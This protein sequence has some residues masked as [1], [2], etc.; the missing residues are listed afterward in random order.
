MEMRLDTTLVSSVRST[1]RE[2]LQPTVPV[3]T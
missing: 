3:V 2:E 1:V